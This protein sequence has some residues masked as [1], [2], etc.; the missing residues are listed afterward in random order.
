[1]AERHD[2]VEPVA[3]GATPRPASLLYAAT[4]T[5]VLIVAGTMVA[6][7]VLSLAVAL[8]LGLRPLVMADESM[9]P[10]IAMGSVVITRTVPAGQVQVG[11]S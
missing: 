10:T 8:V 3:Q 6:V 11:G 2:R 9:D 5:G 1:M 7:A 4:R